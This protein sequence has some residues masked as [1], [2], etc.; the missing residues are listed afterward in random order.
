M[1]TF[2]EKTTLF[3]NFPHKMQFGGIF[4]R[5]KDI[6]SIC[7]AIVSPYDVISWCVFVFPKLFIFLTI[8]GA[9]NLT[10]LT[11]FSSESLCFNWP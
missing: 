3:R 4:F 8:F 1:T 2:L 9:R 6:G 7:I 10:Y 5:K 11:T